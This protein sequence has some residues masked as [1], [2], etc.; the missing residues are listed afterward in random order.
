LNDEN[1][2]ENKNND[3]NQENVDEKNFENLEKLDESLNED[4]KNANS[5]NTKFVSLHVIFSFL[6]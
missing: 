5:M 4:L 6:I 3:R 2:C 1:S